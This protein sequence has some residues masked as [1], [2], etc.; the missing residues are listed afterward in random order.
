M[1]RLLE[2]SKRDTPHKTM[3]SIVNSGTYMAQHL[4]ASDAKGRGHGGDSTHVA[5]QLQPREGLCRRTLSSFRCSKIEHRH[6]IPS[7]GHDDHLMVYAILFVIPWSSNL[8]AS[9][10]EVRTSML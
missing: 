3:E 7:D 10:A 5:R 8:G 9:N 4:V 1:G 2:S 6:W